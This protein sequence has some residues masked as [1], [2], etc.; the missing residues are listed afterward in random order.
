MPFFSILQSALDLSLEFLTSVQPTYPLTISG[1]YLTGWLIQ[2]SFWLDCEFTGIG[3]ENGHEICWH[4][5]LDHRKYS[6]VPSQS[7]EGV[8]NGRFSLGT[9]VI[10][11][12]LAYFVT[13]LR[14]V[15]RGRKTVRNS[16]KLE[17]V[18]A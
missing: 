10:T 3:F 8:V 14:A 18:G 13:S 4:V 6:M 11:L 9:V 5:D 1:I 15:L 16:I 17:S 12:Y 7:S 2:W